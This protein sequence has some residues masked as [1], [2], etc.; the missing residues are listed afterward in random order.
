M[1]R[2][3]DGAAPPGDSCIL[4]GALCTG[5]HLRHKKV[6]CSQAYPGDG[7]SGEGSEKSATLGTKGLVASTCSLSLRQ[8][9]EETQ[10]SHLAQYIPWLFFI[11]GAFSATF[12]L[13]TLQSWVWKKQGCLQIWMS[14]AG[15]CLSSITLGHW[16]SFW[17]TGFLVKLRLR[18]TS[19]I[20][21]V[22]NCAVLKL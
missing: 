17:L 19:S 12:P 21:T 18:M 16:V 15:P 6:H 3:E 22:T 5:E 2:V 20:G 7:A 10:S 13:G 8:E 1:G 9:A 4:R 14:L 11:P